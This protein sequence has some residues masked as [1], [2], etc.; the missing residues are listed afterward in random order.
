M[1]HAWLKNYLATYA[2]VFALSVII[3][4]MLSTMFSVSVSF[5]VKLGLLV[6]TAGAGYVLS[7]ITVR[8]V[9]H[10]D[11]YQI[12]MARIVPLIGVVTVVPMSVLAL[13]FGII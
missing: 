5:M 10:A 11:T 6:M 13:L 3:G 8:A 9:M 4:F 7:M 2:A 12:A 1:K